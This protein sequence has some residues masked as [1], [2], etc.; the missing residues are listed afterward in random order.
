[1]LSYS[2][3]DNVELRNYPAML[4]TT[5]FH[6]SQMQYWEQAKWVAKI[7]DLKTDSNLLLLHTQMGAG[8]SGK[9][10]RFEK[11]RITVLE[12]AFMLDLLGITE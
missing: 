1:M 7:R 10:G 9:S 12:Y 6:D 2:P 5:V 8:H 11:Y 3:Y 4:V